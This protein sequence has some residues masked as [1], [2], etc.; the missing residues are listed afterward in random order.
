MISKVYKDQEKR[1][2]PVTREK[3]NEAFK[4]N[5]V[6]R[7]PSEKTLG[8]TEVLACTASAQNRFS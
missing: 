8:H 3:I 5:E 1:Y 4:Q 7:C 2:P 6:R